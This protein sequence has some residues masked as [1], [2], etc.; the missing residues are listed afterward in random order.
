MAGSQKEF[1]LL[2]KLKATLGGDFKK[3]FKEAVD[4]QKQLRE[5]LKNVNSV[6]SKIDGF[7]KQSTAIDKNKQKLEALRQ[8][9]DRLQ[10]ELNET[11]E[12]TEA[13]RRKLE[14]NESQIQQTTARIKEQEQQLNSLG[15]ELRQAGV[16]TDNLTGENER[17]QKSYD[18]L[19]SSQ[20]TLQSLN[21]RQQEIQ[22]SIGKTKSQLTG[23]LGAITAVGTAI[24][25]GPVKK[26]AEFQE[27]M[28]TVGAI[29]NASAEDMARLSQ[30]AKEM[31]A[32]TAFTAAEAGEAMEYMAMAGW[33]AE[34]MMGGIEGIMNLAAASGEDLA[35]TSDIVTD[36]LTAFGMTAKDAG[37]FSDILAAASSNANTNVSMMGETFKYVAPL[38]G[39]FGFSAEDT[40]LAAGLM[41]NSGIKASQAGTTLRS[42]LS[43]L[44]KPT[45]EMQSTMVELGL[46]VQQVEH[47][48]DGSK[49]DKLQ[50]K[51]ADRTAAMQKAQISY[52]NAVAKYGA[53]SAQAQKSAINLENA[54]RKLAQTSGDLSSAQAGSN[55]VVGIQN[56][57]LTDGN[58][59]MK[60][61]Y[62]VMVKLRQS[63]AGM[64]EEQ[65]TQ[66]AATLFGQEAMSGM[67]AV[68][69]ASDED[70]EKLAGSIKDCNGSAEKMAQMKLDNMNGQITLM[71]SA[72]DALQVELGELLLPVLTEGI[73]KLTGVIGVMTTFVREN[74]E[75]VKT[76]AKVV[77]ALATMR[78]GFLSL[79]LAGLTG[80]SGIISIIQKL[81]G[82]RAGM[83]E[84]AATSVS[85]VTKLKGAGGGI[86]SYFGNVG[87][88]LGGVKSAIGNV[89]SGNAVIGKVTGFLGGIRT[90]LV[91]GI[92]G[93]AGKAAGAL[94]GAGSRMVGFILT[95]FKAIGGRLGGVLSGLGSVIANS[96]LGRIGAVIGGGISKAF[97]AVGS[98][99]APVGN[100]IKA[101][102]GPIGTL[103]KTA[104]GPLGG[105]AAKVLPIVGVVTTVITVF[106]M[107]K[108]HLQ[109]IREFIK[110]T[111]G[112]EALAVFDKVVEV[113]TSVGETIKNIF[114]DGN[115]GAAREKIQEI[116]GD[117]GTAVFDKL[118]GILR[119]V[120]PV[121]QEVIGFLMSN[122]VPVVENILN[123]II[124]Q[125][126]PG[127]V[128][129][130]QSAAPHIMEIVGSVVD[131]I[132]EAIPVIAA[133]IKALMPIISEIID[134]ISTYVLPAIGDVFSFITS[135]V[136]PIISQMVKALLPVIQSVLQ[137]LVPAVT[138]AVTTI[139]N[140]VSPIIKGILQAVQ[141]AMPTILSIV[142]A[143]VTAIG[144][145]IN[146]L[147]TTLQGIITF[148]KGVFTGNWRQAWEGV[149]QIFSGIWE[150][151]KS[152]AQG[153]IDAITGIINGIT[154]KIS[155]LMDKISGAKSAA[156][157]SK[158]SSVSIPGHAKGTESTEN[159]F[160]AGENGPE[161]ITGQPKKVVYTAEETRN[162]FAAQ[163]AAAE[164]VR[165]APT[166]S[167]VKTAPTLTAG[168]GSGSGS[169][170]I[171]INNNPTIIING[172]KPDDLEEKLERNNQT[173]LQQVDEK[174]SGSED[175]G[176]T[177]FE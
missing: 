83:I 124:G 76:I 169:K 93:I 175:E 119:S 11:G 42:A 132:K 112:D 62:E 66:A 140:V 152:I 21:A 141:A 111:F 113:I 52:N 75:A 155:G 47:V 157:S 118:I 121:V 91:S 44:V 173:L 1:E 27:Q 30:K 54:K 147:A 167:A 134:F 60:S 33:K 110:K 123:L 131:F 63:F 32:K 170:T 45:S 5:S 70:F 29:S 172:D 38:A 17:L 34:D 92:A 139:W 143:V 35:T 128:S 138:S 109:E 154:D 8:E 136:L 86:L 106:K 6:Q 18:K 115:I 148:I 129:F 57:L 156:G 48:V 174:L 10:Q 12:P 146:G 3:S 13:L 16:N 20:E 15:E 114:S 46:A 120:I 53:D 59:K 4:T 78:V 72:F 55:Q 77:A 144:G 161:L 133:A 65:Q 71:K 95:P 40:A 36:A 99:I 158:S 163:R 82:L 101:I 125:V 177:R 96:P 22:Q 142:K 56:A 150:S 102:L 24:Y 58:G 37:H 151:I 97:G 80:E 149:K 74:P 73:K 100:A 79:K 28:S 61:F 162:I 25:A 88:A 153:V 81:V 43:R 135:E 9:H 165:T 137:T 98:L 23:T 108:E 87:T 64:T 49:V 89:F 159:A 166:M 107:V 84:S 85:F 41:A 130:M 168:K 94:T 31:G 7:T 145:V 67:L 26:A 103:A 117:K 104:L 171:T 69:N 126:I 160:I 122:V 116:F 105:I 176:R 50:G 90:K 51:V 127:I 2:F 19:K 14:R 39:T 164:A 68:I